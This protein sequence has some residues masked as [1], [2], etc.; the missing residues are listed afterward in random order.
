VGYGSTTIAKGVR[1]I[2]TTGNDFD[3]MWAKTGVRDEIEIFDGSRNSMISGG[4]SVVKFLREGSKY[5]AI[6]YDRA[7]ATTEKLSDNGI[8]WPKG[9]AF[10]IGTSKLDLAQVMFDNVVGSLLLIKADIQ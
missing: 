9:D 6:L 8:L 5:L 1:F 2:E 7:D 3:G 4:I 10:L